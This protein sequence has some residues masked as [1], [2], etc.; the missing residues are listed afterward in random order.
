MPGS[1]QGEIQEE[2][3]EASGRKVGPELGLA[4][5]PEFIALGSVVR[6]MQRPDFILIGESDEA[7]GEMLEIST[8]ARAITIPSF[9][10]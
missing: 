6:D 10:A 5:N 8:S 9:A 1:M 4:Y 3:E 2:L 7:T